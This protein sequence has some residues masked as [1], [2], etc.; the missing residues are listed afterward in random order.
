MTNSHQN[1]NRLK[2]PS[3]PGVLGPVRG[4]R[5][6]TPPK[7]GKKILY[8]N[9]DLRLSEYSFTAS[10]QHVLSYFAFI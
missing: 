8:R 1:E 3:R 7:L 4:S 6:L 9:S 10:V 5:G 2:L